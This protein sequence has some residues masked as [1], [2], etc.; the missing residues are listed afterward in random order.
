MISIVIPT[1]NRAQWLSELVKA[2]LPQIK[3]HDAE[4]IIVDDAS[5][6]T[7]ELVTSLSRNPHI[8]W[9]RNEEHAGPSRSRNKGAAIAKSD[10]IIFLD[11]DCLPPVNWLEKAVSLTQQTTHDFIIGAVTYTPF[12]GHYPERIVQNPQAYWPMSAHLFWKK[13]SF[14]KIGGFDTAFDEYHNEDTELALR[15][16]AR[17]MTYERAPTVTVDH[18]ASY[19]DSH[20]LIRSAKNAGVWPILKK[21]YPMDY[22]HFR[23]AHFGGILFYPVEYLYIIL[24]PVLLPFLLFRYLMNNMHNSRGNFP[25]FFLKWPLFFILRRFHIWKSAITHKTVAF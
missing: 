6:D 12:I 11:D 8:T 24:Y 17:G 21:K 2:L 14:E 16:I 7:T 3:K 13:E 22:T 5:K 4:L 10:W 19:F 23:I 1:R 18:R 20:T 25:M 15:A 9:L